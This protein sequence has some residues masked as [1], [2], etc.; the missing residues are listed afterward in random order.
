MLFLRSE[1]EDMLERN[2]DVF[3]LP[4]QYM[5]DVVDQVFIIPSVEEGINI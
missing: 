3:T 5:P 1:K 2:D 4:W